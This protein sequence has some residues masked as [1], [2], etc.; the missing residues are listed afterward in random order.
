MTATYLPFYTVS[1]RDKELTSSPLQNQ[2]LSE[3][4][5]TPID[6]LPRLESE[7]THLVLLPELRHMPLH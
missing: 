4:S 5:T 2:I 1:A 3:P 6:A 7:M